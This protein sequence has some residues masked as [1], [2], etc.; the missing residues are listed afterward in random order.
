[1]GLNT[2]Y[3]HFIESS[4]E[5]VFGEDVRGL[6]MLELG[7]QV[8][9]DPNITEKTGKNYFTNR[10]YEHV[11][12]DINGLHGAVVRDLTRQKQF[13]DWHDSWD[14]ITNSGTTEH[15]VPFKSQYDCFCI[16]HD[17]LKVGGI[18][19]H[20]IPDVCEHDERNTCNNHCP[21][22]YS[23]SFFGLL[24][25]ECEYELLSNT[26]INGHRCATVRKVKDIPFM[27]DRSKFLEQIA[28]RDFRPDKSQNV[29]KSALRWMGVE[30]LLRRI[31]LR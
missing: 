16:I 20:L 8:I 17:C 7:D 21:Y 25:K 1:M 22:Y 10:G 6:R 19:V 18:A 12:V 29:V 31:G 28:K 24:A 9:R 27:K 13:Q 26:V 14:I 23:E 15:V 5:Q 4:I 3:L 2:S 11:S 30:K